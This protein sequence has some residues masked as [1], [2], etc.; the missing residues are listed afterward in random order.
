MSLPLCC[1]AREAEDRPVV[2]CVC[3]ALP[4]DFGLIVVPLSTFAHE[5]EDR[6][7]SVCVRRALPG[8]FGLIV[9]PL[10]TFARETKDRPMLVCCF[11]IEWFCNLGSTDANVFA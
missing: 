8:V 10:S 2:I 3:R 5:A 7:V 4:G 6:P 11:I 1:I 9:V